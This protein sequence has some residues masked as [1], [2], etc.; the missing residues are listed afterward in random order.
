MNTTRIQQIINDTKKF[1]FGTGEITAIT[2]IFS[3]PDFRAQLI[4]WGISYGA[5]EEKWNE[6]ENLLKEYLK[7]YKYQIKK[8]TKFSPRTMHLMINNIEKYVDG[9]GKKGIWEVISSRKIVKEYLDQN[10]IHFDC[11]IDK[12]NLI[13]DDFI[14]TFQNDSIPIIPL[15]NLKRNSYKKLE[16]SYEMLN[17]LAKNEPE[18]FNNYFTKLKNQLKISK[19]KQNE[20]L[21]Q[22]NSILQK[23]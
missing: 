21:K 20:I 14:K 3:Q 17:F 22:T 23:I 1:I 13:K 8:L 12:W 11:G 18:T 9:I 6:I 10:N 7:N 5:G 19:Q 4:A 2:N 16:L 15:K